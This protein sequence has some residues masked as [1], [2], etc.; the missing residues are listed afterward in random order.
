MSN[1]PSQQPKKRP[2][3]MLY[4]FG[5]L[6][7]C[8]LASFA[9]FSALSNSTPESTGPKP[10]N[11]PGTILYRDTPE[12]TA[13]SVGSEAAAWTACE[14]FVTERLKAPA[15][16]EFSGFDTEIDD[17]GDG[18]YIVSGYVDAEN[19]LG[20]TV[21]SN[22]VCEVEHETGITYDLINLAVIPR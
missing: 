19:S 2:N 10:T 22:Y 3:P 12:P 13:P 15:S 9:G 8:A 6:A 20:A 4:F 11:T 17:L 18:H 7:I 16:A 1:L 14:R 5:T 21:R